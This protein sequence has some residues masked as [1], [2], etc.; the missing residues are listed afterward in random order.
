MAAFNIRGHQ[1]NVGTTEALQKSSFTEQLLN[2][3]QRGAGTHICT[4]G[5]ENPPSFGSAERNKVLLLFPEK[6][7]LSGCTHGTAVLS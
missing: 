7:H 4:C 6:G 3:L 5:K 1:C 2:V